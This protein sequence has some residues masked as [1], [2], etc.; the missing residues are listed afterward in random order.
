[1]T[2]TSP[3]AATQDIDY[4]DFLE[5]ILNIENNARLVHLVLSRLRSNLDDTMLDR[6][7]HH[8]HIMQIC[9]ESYRLKD[10]RKAGQVKV[11]AW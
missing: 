9:R 8:A 6:L 3:W 11:K 5:K 10:K 7:R 4:G 1:M 2:T